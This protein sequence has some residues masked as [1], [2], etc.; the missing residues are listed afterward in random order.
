[1]SLFPYVHELDGGELRR[2]IALGQAGDRDARERA[3]WGIGRVVNTL[4][5]AFARKHVGDDRQDLASVGAVALLEA[6]DA[7]PAGC[8]ADPFAWC[9]VRVHGAMVVYMRD[10]KCKGVRLSGSAASTYWW[11][12]R[13]SLRL[14]AAGEEPT[15]ERVLATGGTLPVKLA[16]VSCRRRLRHVRQVL[17]VADNF[18]SLD[19]PAPGG[20]DESVGDVLLIATGREYDRDPAEIA[21]EQAARH[22][23]RRAVR[24]ALATLPHHHRQAVELAF[25]NGECWSTPRAHRLGWTMHL[26]ELA[27]VSPDVFSGRYRRGIARLRKCHPELFDY[28]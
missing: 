20:G 22:L 10:E 11:V 19:A 1:M 27:G 15:P 23:R 17:E 2:L 28:A 9:Y 12:R 16:R 13:Q 14:R 18:V 3:F 7:Y 21:G 26:A 24:V 5:A 4:L 8:A 6:I 25:W